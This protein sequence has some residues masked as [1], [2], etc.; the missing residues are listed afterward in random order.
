MNYL[1]VLLFLCYRG[2]VSPLLHQA[3]PF[4]SA[5]RFSPTCSAYG[6][7]AVRQYGLCRGF[8]V[9]MRR[10]S[11]CHPWGRWGQDQVPRA[12]KQGCR[13]AGMTS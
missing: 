6:L 13:G 8:V 2:V 11:R 7:D 12:P 4:P 1:L 9:L 10:L 3:L 5:C